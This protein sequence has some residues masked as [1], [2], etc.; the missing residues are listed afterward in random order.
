MIEVTVLGSGSAGNALLIQ[1]EHSALLVDAGFSARDLERRCL[2]AGVS[3][4]GVSA[5]LV[6]HEHGDHIKGLGP[7]ARRLGAPVYCNRLTAEA[8]RN[9][10]QRPPRSMNL[11][12]AGMPFSIGE[13]DIEPF[14]IPHDAVDPVGFVIHCDGRKIAVATDLGFAGN[15]VN[16]VLRDSDLL[17]LESNHDVA[18]LLASNRPW[19]LKQRIMSRHGHLS[20]EACMDLLRSVISEKTRQVILAHASRECNSYELV[21]DQAQQCLAEIGRPEIRPLV[22]RQDAP[23]RPVRI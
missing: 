14:S 22:A 23:L 20:N 12:G 16:H 1:N 17:V 10:Q 9:T 15:L 7:V 11:F 21:E 6:S 19:P 8:I 4:A 18:M 2:A 5:I 13:F 3:L